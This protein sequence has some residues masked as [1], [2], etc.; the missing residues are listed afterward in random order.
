MYKTYLPLRKILKSII[1]I[2]SNLISRTVATVLSAFLLLSCSTDQLEMEGP[3]QVDERICLS[4]D[5]PEVTVS[6]DG[7]VAAVAYGPEGGTTDI[8]VA[9]TLVWE[10]SVS[11]LEGWCEVTASGRGLLIEAGR[12]MENTG[13]EGKIR[14][15]SDG[16]DVAEIKISQEGIGKDPALLLER[17]S[18]SIFDE[19]GNIDV[20]V[21]TNQPEWELSE[22]KT[23]CKEEWI[24][25]EKDERGKS[26]SIEISANTDKKART[27]T[28]VFIGKEKGTK[29]VESL[30]TIEQWGAS[31]VLE[32]SAQA[33][34]KI[35][36]PLKGQTDVRVAWG[37]DGYAFETHTL[38]VE[39]EEDYITHLYSEPGTYMVHIT[40]SAPVMTYCY[41]DDSQW[42]G[43]VYDRLCEPITS[44][45]KWG[46]LG[47]V[48]MAYAFHSTSITTVPADPYGY[49][50][51]VKDIRGIFSENTQF[52]GVPEGFFAGMPG[53]TSFDNIFSGCESLTSVPADIFAGNTAAVSFQGTFSGSG[54][55]EI[56]E[57]LFRNNRAATSFSRTFYG[58]PVCSIPE[59]LFSGNGE[60]FMFEETFAETSVSGIPA[61][62]FSANG[63]TASLMGCFS[64]TPITS[65]PAGLIKDFPDLYDISYLFYG[66]SSLETVAP[67]TFG[68]CTAIESAESLFQ[69]CSSLETVPQGLFDDMDKVVYMA[70]VFNNASS[71]KSIP[72][73]IF[74]KCVSA[75]DFTYAFQSCTSLEEVPAHVFPASAQKLPSIFTG[76][77]SLT[78]ISEDAFAGVAGAEF[79]NYAFQRCTSLASIPEGLFEDC[80]NCTAFAYCFDQCSALT[81]VPE[82]LF[83]GNKVINGYFGTNYM[84]ARCSSLKSIPADLFSTFINATDFK[85]AFLGCQSLE[86]IPEGLF[87]NCSKVTTY[88]GV[89]QD[90]SSLKTVPA[91]LFDNGMIVKDFSRVFYGCG[92]IEGESP[93]T[94][95]GERR[96]H[97]YERTAEDGFTVPTNTSM[98]FKDA[99][100][101]DM[102]AVPEK[103]R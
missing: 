58:T 45:V 53:I 98:A 94:V 103:W 51:G 48:S 15:K 61:S 60:A 13:R 76:C 2:K 44:V 4:S 57:G 85:Y 32:V 47:T 97:L 9:T 50:S 34:T 86:S 71:L 46:D 30:L 6:G 75:T 52:K 36:L 82:R 1:M 26:L 63:K 27:A 101:S 72:E 49:L 59:N 83:S 67:D 16:K 19:G 55:E 17:E 21:T 22:I 24:R 66:C 43:Y 65:V 77:T 69:N 80:V 7:A 78:S 38:Y 10:F 23:D 37:D 93:Y 92:A 14:I 96:V 3:T 102:D 12:F 20:A 39:E 28:L 89:F 18:I 11:G 41:D 73:G 62:L 100:F 68:G 79:L 91:G 56:P 74:S 95:I 33:G 54:L 84:F 88:C 81:S 8:M 99:S 40:G 64:D 5:D 90:C 87:D 42:P 25:A 29:T 31:L 35:A 70:S